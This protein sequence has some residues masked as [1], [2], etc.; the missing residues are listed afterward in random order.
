M[1][2]GIRKRNHYTCAR[3]TLHLIQVGITSGF[4]A[5]P[6]ISQGSACNES[7]HPSSLSTTCTEKP[8]ISS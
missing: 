8:G 6:H 4:R 1:D 5:E 3:F 7:E 2:K